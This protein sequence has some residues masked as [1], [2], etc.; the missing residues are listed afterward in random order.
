MVGD[1]VNYNIKGIKRAKGHR[2]VRL[3][4]DYGARKN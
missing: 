2:H 3:K 4:K 1:N